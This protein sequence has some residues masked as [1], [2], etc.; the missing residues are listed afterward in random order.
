MSAPIATRN[1]CSK[2][3]RYRHADHMGY[4]HVRMGYG[5]E[6]PIMTPLIRTPGLMRE[7]P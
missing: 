2:S 4:G 7:F 1:N 5:V 6:L 3:V